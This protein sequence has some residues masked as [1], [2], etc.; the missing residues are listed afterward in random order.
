MS[1]SYQNNKKRK[2]QKEKMNRLI[3]KQ[4]QETALDNMIRA[5]KKSKIEEALMPDPNK[6]KMITKIGR[7]LRK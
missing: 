7:F 4:E 2:H 1:I 3:R 6:N 5:Y